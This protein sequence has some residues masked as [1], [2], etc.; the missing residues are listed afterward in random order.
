[1]NS[2]LR[3]SL[4]SARRSSEPLGLEHADLA[5]EAVEEGDVARLVGDLRGEEDAHVLA[6]RGAHHRPELGGHALLADEE[7]R[8]PVHARVALLGVDPLVPVDAVLREVD[9]LDRPLLALPQR[10][11]L[12]VGE[13]V[14]L[15]AIGAL[16]Q[17]RVARGA[18]VDAVGAGGGGVGHG[19]PLSSCCRSSP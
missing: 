19:G 8:Q 4:V 14:R 13:Q 3:C 6:R 18:E 17:R 9:V 1:M 10:V 7:R 5:V 11:E 16:E 2:G 15:A 12:A